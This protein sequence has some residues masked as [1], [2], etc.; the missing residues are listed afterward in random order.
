MKGKII[1]L[2]VTAAFTA[3]VTQAEN[4]G[5]AGAFYGLVESEDVETGNLG[6]LVGSSWN[7]GVG[8]EFMY[9]FTINEE[10]L[11]EGPFTAD[12]SIDTLGLYATYT[13]GEEFYLRGKAGY[14]KVDLEFD[15]E[16]L[17]SIDD[18]TSDFSFGVSFGYRTTNGA[19]E[20]TYL[21]LP[22]FD[23]FQGIEVDADVDMLSIGYNFNF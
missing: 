1:L 18:D 12:V 13:A 9:S 4:Q 6:I 10:E 11:S 14:A 17:G 22:E 20:L 23:D 19:L 21:V 16:G 5:Y 8:I 7:N 3:P 2:L 15:F